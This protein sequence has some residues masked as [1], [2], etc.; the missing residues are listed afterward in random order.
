ME[1]DLQQICALEHVG[2]AFVCDNTGEVVVSSTPP[3]LATIT[4]NQIGRSA[5]QTFSAMETAKRPV[6][7]MEI[8]Y[9]A[10]RLFVR[11][12][13]PAMVVVVCQPAVDMA[14]LRMTVDMVTVRWRKENLLQKRLGKKNP[15]PRK[16]LLTEA[17]LDDAAW[18][19]YR[20]FAPQS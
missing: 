3:V 14:M 19:S 9:D 16:D 7:R 12:L 10:W 6:E 5:V 17:H 11:D 2:G 13:G 15:P 1:R 4:M 8:I 20:L 18:R